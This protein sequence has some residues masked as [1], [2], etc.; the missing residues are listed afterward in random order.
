MSIEKLIE[1][2][3]GKNVTVS[4]KNGEA[5][6]G[7]IISISGQYLHLEILNGTINGLPR[8]NTKALYLPKLVDIKYN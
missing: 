3:E 4:K 1:G 8:R 7:E 6:T 2:K 5:Y